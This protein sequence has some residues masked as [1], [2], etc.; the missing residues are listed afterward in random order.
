MI[1]VRAFQQ[2]FG[3]CEI[4]QQL[5]GIIPTIHFLDNYDLVHNTIKLLDQV[6]HFVNNIRSVPGNSLIVAYLAVFA[7]NLLL[8]DA[9]LAEKLADLRYE[10]TQLFLLVNVAHEWRLYLV[11][12]RH[13]VRRNLLI[14]FHY[15]EVLFFKARGTLNTLTLDIISKVLHDQVTALQ[16]DDV[17]ARRKHARHPL[18]EIVLL[19][20]AAAF[21]F[22][23]H[24]AFQIYF[25]IYKYSI[26]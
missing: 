13:L 8:G 25:S 21:V 6:L 12:V 19:L 24:S 22:L 20:A 4:L 23:V 15:I 26:H 18:R 11:L 14:H 2:L 10:V 3:L 16:A 7:V 17:P 1:Y 9:E 5:L